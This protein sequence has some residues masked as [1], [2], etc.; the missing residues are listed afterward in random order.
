[1]GYR[2]G[3]L[4][5]R[6]GHF[7]FPSELKTRT[8][9][10]ILPSN[11]Q[12]R[13][14]CPL[15]LFQT[16]R[17]SISIVLNNRVSLS[18]YPLSSFKNHIVK[19]Q[20]IL[21]CFTQ[22]STIL[23][24]VR[25]NFHLHCSLTK[26]IS[27]FHY[28]LSILFPLVQ[29]PEIPQVYILHTQPFPFPSLPFPSHQRRSKFPY[30]QLPHTSTNFP[31]HQHNQS[32]NPSTKMQPCKTQTTFYHTCT[33]SLTTAH[34]SPCCLTSTCKIP[35]PSKLVFIKN[36]ECFWCAGAEKFPIYP[37]GGL[38]GWGKNAEVEEWQKEERRGLVEAE[39][40]RQM[41]EGESMCGCRT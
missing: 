15:S 4:K 36:G 30:L 16:K 18:D 29:L 2:L 5:Y 41:V 14:D 3:T 35:S 21:P 13:L 17:L 9:I 27:S 32:T 19:P 38:G 34:H 11:L 10:Q 40:K 23:K 8:Q 31:I 22:G 6:V 33:H 7:L 1:M 24:G 26:Y 25:K 39:V 28:S 12:I 20:T 37:G